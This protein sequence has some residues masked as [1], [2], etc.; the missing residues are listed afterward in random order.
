MAACDNIA[1]PGTLSCRVVCNTPG[2]CQRGTAQAPTC[3]ANNTNEAC[4]ASC[5]T[6]V[7]PANG[8]VTCNGTSCVPACTTGFHLCGTGASATCAPNNSSCT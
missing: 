1:T 2:F 3:V 6:C 8:T 4:G 5:A 7:A